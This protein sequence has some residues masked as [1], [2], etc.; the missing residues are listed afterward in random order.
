MKNGRKFSDTGLR[1]AI[2]AC[3][4]PITRQG[5]VPLK[6]SRL[7]DLERSRPLTAWMLWLVIVARYSD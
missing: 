1:S 7:A 2:A 4:E 3:V 5:G 6:P